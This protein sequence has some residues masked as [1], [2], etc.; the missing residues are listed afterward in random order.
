MFSSQHLLQY[1]HCWNLN[2]FIYLKRETFTNNLQPT[3][4]GDGQ[5]GEI[6]HLPTFK[7]SVSEQGEQ[8]REGKPPKGI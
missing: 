8:N 2:L 4:S 7:Q 6:L 5:S 3:C 1:L